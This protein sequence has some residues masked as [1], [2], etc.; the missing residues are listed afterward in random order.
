M[1]LMDMFDEEE[2]VFVLVTMMMM[3]RMRM[4]D[5]DVDD[6]VH[7]IDEN[8]MVAVNINHQLLLWDYYFL[9]AEMKDVLLVEIH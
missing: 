5:D 3:M 6:N 7:V 2:I 1:A 8:L 9:V 4:N